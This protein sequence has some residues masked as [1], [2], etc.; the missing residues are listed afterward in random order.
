NKTSRF[1]AEAALGGDCSRWWISE[2]PMQDSACYGMLTA[3][4]AAFLRTTP[5]S[6]PHLDAEFREEHAATTQRFGVVEGCGKRP[7]ALASIHSTR[8]FWLR[9]CE[10]PDPDVTVYVVVGPGCEYD[11][12]CHERGYDEGCLPGYPAVMREIRI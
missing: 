1:A 6:H 12:R 2:P 11:P 8:A 5:D 3:H 9:S 4:V 10:A 7:V